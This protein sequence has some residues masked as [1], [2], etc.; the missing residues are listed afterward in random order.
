MLALPCLIARGGLLDFDWLVKHHSSIERPP[1]CAESLVALA[2]RRSLILKSRERSVR[3]CLRGNRSA[4]V[5][6]EYDPIS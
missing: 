4:C 6:T 1:K 2:T 3:S 5:T